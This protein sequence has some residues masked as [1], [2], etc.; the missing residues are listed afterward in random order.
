[1]AR[2][3]SNEQKVPDPPGYTLL[4]KLG[5][6]GFG[7]VYRAERER[8][9]EIVALKILAPP[10]TP[11]EVKMV[12]REIQTLTD[13]DRSR[14]T[15][16]ILDYGQCENGEPY[17]AMQYAQFGHLKCENIRTLKDAFVV[18]RHVVSGLAMLHIDRN[19][20]HRDLKPMNILKMAP[21][22]YAIADFGLSRV[23]HSYAHSMVGTRMYAAPEVLRGK[24]YTFSADIYSLGLIFYQLIHRDGHLPE[25][26]KDLSF[27]S[28]LGSQRR[29]GN[30]YDLI[31]S[32]LSEDPLLRPSAGDVYTALHPPRV[33]RPHGRPRRKRKSQTSIAVSVSAVLSALSGVAVTAL[34]SGPIVNKP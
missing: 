4:D 5:A 3:N 1:M 18:M 13:L 34:F 32:M 29:N 27:R 7:S 25:R 14:Y 26:F 19:I 15:V 10:Q 24:K 11:N 17:I 22:W 6:G 33:R 9:F 23:V 20:M 30:L 28:C 8:D 16:D 31:T 12:Q 21:H 2:R